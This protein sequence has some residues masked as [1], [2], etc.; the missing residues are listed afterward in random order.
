MALSSAKYA[1]FD[2]DR[3]VVLF[4][5]S[6]GDA[7]NVPCAVSAEALDQLDRPFRAKP[8]QRE[9]QFERLRD[10]V[11]LCAVRKFQNAEF[12]GTSKRLV[13]RS[14]DFR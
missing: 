2:P 6:E 1:R 10:R 7:S 4:S 11:E 12:E 5:M 8:E 3:M 14:I 13:L 9:Q